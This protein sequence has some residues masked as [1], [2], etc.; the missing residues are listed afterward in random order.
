MPLRKTA[1]AVPDDLLAAV[2]RVARARRESRNRFVTRVL[3]HAV[4]ARRDTE[5]TRRLNELFAGAGSHRKRLVGRALVIRQGGI[6]WLH[7]GPAE[8][9][10]P[11]GRR[12]AL[13]VQHDRFNRSAI[14]TT[15]VAAVTSNLRLGAMPGNVRLRRGEAGLSRASVVNV[16]QIRTIDRTRLV[17]CV[18]ILG[19]GKMRDVLKGLALLLG[20]DEISDDGA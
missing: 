19:A 13:V 18:G 2:D 3:Q 17:D 10:A 1:I 11:A 15:V 7:F 5:I 9:S 6:Y 12:P 20:T 4:R 16:S 14:S 8:G